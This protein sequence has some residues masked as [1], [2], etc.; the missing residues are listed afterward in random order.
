MNTRNSLNFVLAVFLFF[1]FISCSK[2]STKVDT[3]PQG[4]VPQVT[5]Q[6]PEESQKASPEGAALEGNQIQEESVTD[7]RPPLEFELIYFDYDMYNIRS[8]MLEKLAQNAKILQSYPQAKIRIEGHCDERGTIDY[9]LALGERRAYS[10]KNYLTN[11]G[12]DPDRIRT[13]SYGKERPAIPGHSES[14]WAKNRRTV[15][16]ITAQ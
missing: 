16:V 1:L 4:S 13:I 3:S 15:F 7:S 9:N 6:E 14:A 10:V 5:V 8:D 2:K 12:I 11:Y